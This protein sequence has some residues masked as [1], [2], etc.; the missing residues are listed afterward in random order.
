V[1]G[2]NAGGCDFLQHMI[3]NGRT[4]ISRDKNKAT[5]GVHLSAGVTRFALRLGGGGDGNA[6]GK[7]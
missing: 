6:I 7:N 4:S 3:G 2:K 1:G 5:W